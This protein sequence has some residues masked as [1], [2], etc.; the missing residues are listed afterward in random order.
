[1]PSIAVAVARDGE[2]VWEEGFGYADRGRRRK[3]DEHTMYS[4]ASISKPFTATGIMVMREQ[5]KLTLEQPI[6]EVLPPPGIRTTVG[7]PAMVTVQR[8]ASHTAGLPTHYLFYFDGEHAAPSDAEVRRR[9]G[10]TVTAPGAQ[11]EYSNL[12]FGLL[13]QV[14]GHL[15]GGTY[16]EVMTR[17]VFEPLGLEHTFV[18]T[19]PRRAGLTAPRYG[20]NGQPLPDYETGH[21]GA[22]DLYSSAHDLV[23]F[24]MFHIGQ[25]QPGQREII[26]AKARALMQT[27]VAPA[28][29]Y[30]L[31]F[32]VGRDDGV[33]RVSHTGGMIGVRT[34]LRMYPEHGVVIAVLTNFGQGRA[35]AAAVAMLIGD[36]MGLPA[37]ADAICA[38]GP[39]HPMIKRWTGE[40][41]TLTG[42]RAMSVQITAQGEVQVSLA[43]AAAVPLRRIQYRDGK[44]SG[45]FLGSVGS[46]LAGESP[47]MQRLDLE[48]TDDRLEGRLSTA[49]PWI[50]STALPVSLHP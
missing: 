5:G 50:A 26:S 31:G 38:L 27:A 35:D 2:I 29:N 21:Y 15:G 33:V 30:G 39:Q 8:V 3:A 44:L 7:D 49:L 48:L 23:R 22:S 34:V 19:P 46:E 47:T 4:L 16:A 14:V 10:L 20:G 9:Y 37:R 12:G 42:P 43:D 28:E 18:G 6:N 25:L 24:G 1:M 40:L 13:G 17:E 45:W 41:T 11:Y 36:A 32:G